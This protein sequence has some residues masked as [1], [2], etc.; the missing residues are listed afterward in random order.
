MSAPPVFILGT[1]RSGS[2]LV[3]LLLDAHPDV[4]VPHPPH[5]VRYFTPL[6]AGYGDLHQDDA[7]RA[8]VADVLTLIETHIHPWPWVPSVDEVVARSVGRSVFAA[9]VAVH[10]A[11]RDHVGKARWGCKS[12]FMIEHGDRILE[13]F[14][15]ARLLWLYRD[16]RDVAASSKRSV[17]STFHPYFTAQLWDRQQRLGLALERRA[18]VLHVR[19][20]SLVTGGEA[21]VRRI[22]DHVGVPWVPEVM[23]FYQRDEAKRTASL[24]ESWQNTADPIKAT[25][26]DRWRAELTPEEVEALE[27]VVGATMTTLGYPLATAANL[28]PSL[29]QHAR[30]AAEEQWHWL[31]VEAR[32]LR[33]DANVGRRW[34]RALLLA[35]LRRRRLG[36]R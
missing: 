20:E 1:E 9:Y 31:Q 19:Y 15:D 25:S 10:E 34:R 28:H 27:T 33:K 30:W 7:W 2:N 36:G 26:V 21:E 14:P 22:F 12:T 8:L 13:R 11:L 35:R 17:F 5:I 24:S 4:V 23:Q 18:E 6:E 29:A 32:S 16:P 3:R